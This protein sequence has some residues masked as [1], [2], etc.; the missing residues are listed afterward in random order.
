MKNQLKQRIKEF[1]KIKFNGNNDKRII[2]AT[3]GL[4][5]ALNSNK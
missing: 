5:K 1:N 2:I 4:T 3:L